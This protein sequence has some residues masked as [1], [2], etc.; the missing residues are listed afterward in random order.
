M[1]Y[2]K[3]DAEAHAERVAP[4]EYA[5][6]MLSETW[7]DRSLIKKVTMRTDGTA[8]LLGAIA[9]PM[10][11]WL[12]TLPDGA[13]ISGRQLCEVFAP[14]LNSDQPDFAM[15]FLKILYTMRQLGNFDGYFTRSKI[16]NRFGKPYV[17]FHRRIK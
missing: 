14:D 12:D 3:F 11:R 2:D 17:N 9:E 6:K 16:K 15:S 8:Q 4:P 10:K 7:K 13:T 1:A 5:V